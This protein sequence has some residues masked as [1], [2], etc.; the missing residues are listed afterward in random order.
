MPPLANLLKATM[1]PI[2]YPTC[3]DYMLKLSL[4]GEPIYDVKELIDPKL[5]STD[6]KYKYM[7]VCVPKCQAST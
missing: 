2:I 7:N 5:E 3:P 4:G 1:Y 6:K